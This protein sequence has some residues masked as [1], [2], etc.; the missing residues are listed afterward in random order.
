M[1]AS[2]VAVVLFVVVAGGVAAIASSAT[3]QI[4]P[5][6]CPRPGF[7]VAP[8]PGADEDRNG[9]N[10]VCVD[11]TTGAIAD[12]VNPPSE[13]H[14]D[15]NADALVCYNPDKGVITDDRLDPQAENGADCPPG[16]ILV[17]VLPFL[18]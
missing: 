6:P 16:F 1:R 3:A 8:G 17:S 12:D 14:K 18:V 10:I 9:D 5:E 15:A 7:V 13:Q 4:T 2:R 11:P